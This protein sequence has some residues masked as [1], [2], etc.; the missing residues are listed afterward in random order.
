MAPIMPIGG[1]E[2]LASVCMETLVL[3]AL[4]LV[5]LA[6]AAWCGLKVRQTLKAPIDE[7]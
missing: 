5:A 4:A 7:E 3:G 1:D 2:A 6:L